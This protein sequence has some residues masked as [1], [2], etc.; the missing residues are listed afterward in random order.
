MRKTILIAVLALFAAAPVLAQTPSIGIYFN[1]QGTQSTGVF[2]GGFDELHTAYVVG[3]GEFVW[4][5]GA[6]K[7]A[8]DPRIV[9]VS[10]SFPAGVQIGDALAGV[11]VGFQDPKAGYYGTPVL[12]ATLTLF[13]GANVFAGGTLEILPFAPRYETV[14][15]S[16]QNGLL[17]EAVGL[18]ATMTIP[19]AAEGDSWGQVKS[20][21]RQ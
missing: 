12:L 18:T 7:V 8:L 17:A 20:L 13:T 21:Y 14:I 11:E 1:P 9:L 4:G 6:F 10:S 19:V 5:G 3:F 16:D 2:N 15:V